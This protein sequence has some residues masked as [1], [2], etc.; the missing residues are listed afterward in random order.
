MQK[1]LFIGIAVG[2][3]A[4]M[5]SLPKVHDMLGRLAAY[6][7]RQTEIYDPPVLFSDKGGNP[8]TG[9]YLADSLTPSLLL[10][11]PRIIVYFIG[12]G[13]FADGEQIWYLSEELAQWAESVSVAGYQE[14]LETYGPDQLCIFSDSC[15]TPE[16]TVGKS[17]PI[18]RQHTGLSDFPLIDTFR[19]TVKGKPAFAPTGVGPIFSDTILNV[20]DNEAY[21]PFAA[22]DPQYL[23]VGKFVVTSQSLANYVDDTVP[24]LANDIRRQQR[25]RTHSGLRYDTDDYLILDGPPGIVAPPTADEI[26]ASLPVRPISLYDRDIG[27]ERDTL[28]RETLSEWRGDFWYQT[29]DRAEHLGPSEGVLVSV[30]AN[31][32]TIPNAQLIF[33]P[34]LETME[35][36][37]TR[38][39]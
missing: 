9:Q 33:T 5:K 35:M 16:V 23:N 25:P 14:V 7:E 21:P 13:A 32:R 8:V 26:L 12:H 37:I 31:R 3:P 1:R 15:Q 4:G 11:R 2:R 28:W 17:S 6:V 24:K 18:L 38:P 34:D 27:A 22:L 30:Q 20:L 36:G 10:E 19:S 29:L 39:G